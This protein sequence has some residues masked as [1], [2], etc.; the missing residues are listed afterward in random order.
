[1]ASDKYSRGN[2]Q[3]D[4]DLPEDRPMSEAV[5]SEATLEARTSSLNELMPDVD[6]LVDAVENVGRYDVVGEQGRGGLGRVL[7]VRDRMLGRY[8][9]LKELV[10]RT[11]SGD[12]AG[13]TTD[14]NVKTEPAVLRFLREARVTAQLEHPSIVPIHDLGRRADGTL[15]YTM[16]L[17]RGQTLSKA[18]SQAA[19]LEERLALL[20]HFVDV[21]QAIAYSHSKGIIHRDI[22]PANIMIGSFGETIVIDWGLAKPARAVE[23][24]EDR[25]NTG[26]EFPRA[27]IDEAIPLTKYGL[28]MGTPHYTPPEQAQGNVDA[29][30]ERSDVYALGAVLYELLTGHRPFK[31][32]TPPDVI[33]EVL[34]SE[35]AP[36][37]RI[38]PKAPAELVAI[39][40]RAM[41]KKPEG[42][43]QTAQALAE[44]IERF[45]TGAYVS[46]YA[47]SSGERLRR[48]ARKHRVALLATC[49]VFLVLVVSG[50]VSLSAILVEKARTERAYYYS[51]I[52]LAKASLDNRRL[53]EARMALQDAAPAYR[54]VEWGLLHQLAH[55]ELV[56][57]RGHTNEVDYAAFNADGSAVVSCAFS[58]R[59]RAIRTNVATTRWARRRP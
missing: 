52:S 31:D 23:T 7:V 41:Q 25:S 47:Y 18:I 32:Q 38:E 26:S 13:D 16:K 22:K 29:I 2:N 49:F 15:Y 50:V 58:P 33:R 5:H 19:S 36:V 43:Y 14:D 4:K 1:M 53:E 56:E 11:P 46:A 30:D 45:K 37:E 51:S 27:P 59:S 28:Y 40:R 24:G 34:I 42:R 57:L 55:P 10:S 12:N 48:L 21:C 39:C 44:E 9:A 17:V 8:I 20:P 54:G 35:P 6:A 3:P